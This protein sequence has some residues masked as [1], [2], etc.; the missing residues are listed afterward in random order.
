MKL[1]DFP[2]SGNGYKA[3]LILA[4]L[5]LA[6]EHILVD[7]LQG[8]TR[9]EGFLAVNPNG[10]IPVLVLDDGRIL[11]ES[12]A[13]LFYLSQGTPYWPGDRF[14]QAQV[15]QWLFFE[16]Y[17][18]EPNLA[19]ARFWLAIK[20]IELTQFYRELLGQKQALGRKALEVME[21]H[22]RAHAFLIG[23]RYTIADMALYAYTHVAHEGGFDMQPYS[24]IAQWLERVR[25][26]AG[27]VPIDAWK[28]L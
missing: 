11:P 18:H 25:G 4:H 15:M 28:P 26:Q 14:E 27:H 9:T 10:K 16:Q 6:Y 20:K 17:S 7:T 12:N 13:I 8:G 3:R 5:G 21:G 1:Y 19:A 24:S 23:G 2:P 22:L